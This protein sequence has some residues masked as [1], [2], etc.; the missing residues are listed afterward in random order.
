VTL[1]FLIDA[2]LPPALAERLR[3][4]GHSANHIVE[5]GLDV[6]SDLEIWRF[7][8]DRG[9]ILVTKDSDFV[10]LVDQDPTGPPVLW[11]RLGNTTN[12]A[13]WQALAPLLSDI[14]AALERGERLV[15]IV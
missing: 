5:I 6:A 9:A 15:E 2:Q 13:L 3:E 7:A 14:I 10:S 4:R 12:R 8:R 11:I 1:L